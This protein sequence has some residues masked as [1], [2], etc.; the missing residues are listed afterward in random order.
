M[1]GGENS[2]LSFARSWDRRI[3]TTATTMRPK[4]NGTCFGIWYE[5]VA[6]SVLL[7]WNDD[8]VGTYYRQYGLVVRAVTVVTARL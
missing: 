5:P 3:H 8:D 1:G 2:G 7:R 4:K 6:A